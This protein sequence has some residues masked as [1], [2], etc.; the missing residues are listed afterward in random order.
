MLYSYLYFYNLQLKSSQIL[1]DRLGTRLR[2]MLIISLLLFY[3]FRIQPQQYPIIDYT[4]DRGL[5]GNQ[6]F[7]I[8]Q[9]SKGYMW[10]CTSSGLTKYNGTEYKV[11]DANDG[12]SSSIVFN[13][14]EDR[15][16]RIWIGSINSIY[17]IDS[18][19]IKSWIIGSS[20]NA[21]R[22]FV[23][24]YNRIW[25]YDFRVPSDVYYF[26]NDS[27]YNFSEDF[28]FKNQQI[29][30]ITENK[31]GSVY[32]LTSDRKVYHFL[33]SSL[34]ETP[35]SKIA[36]ENEANHLFFNSKGN[37][38]FSGNKGVIETYSSDTYESIESRTLLAEPTAYTI[39][40]KRGYYWI[41][42]S[43][44]GLYRVSDSGETIH[45]T[46]D[47]GLP[48]NLLYTL[49]QDREGNLW[50][51]ASSKGISKLSSLAITAY[52]NAEG[53]E[54]DAILFICPAE[55]NSFYCGTERGMFLFDE[56]RFERVFLYDKSGKDYSYSVFAKSLKIKDNKFI[57]A[58]LNRLLFYN[59]GNRLT[60]LELYDLYVTD[61]YQTSRGEI[62]I[63]TG[64]GLFLL[65]DDD[66]IMPINIDSPVGYIYKILEVDNRDLYVAADSGLVIIQ[67]GTIPVEQKSIHLLNKKSGLDSD[68]VDDVIVSKDNE[69]IIAGANGI[70]V[71]S[72]EN[73]SIISSFKGVMA[74]VLFSDSNGNLWAG[75]T[76]GLY[77][78]RKLN[79]KYELVTIF[80]KNNGLVSNE[81]TMPGTIW[82]DSLGSIWF[83]S[84]GGLSVFDPN[85]VAF[86]SIKP[87]FYIADIFVNDSM[88]T[89]SP[90]DNYEFAPGQNK[91]S[92]NLEALSFIDEDAVKYEYYLEPIEKPWAN[93][94][95]FN[96][97]SYGY[98]EPGLYIF[99]AR[100]IN[101]YRV[102]SVVQSA[103][104]EI[105]APVWQRSWFIALLLVAL[106]ALIYLWNYYRQANIRKRN[107]ILE[108]T[109]SKKTAELLLSKNKIEEQYNSLVEAQK[110]LVEKEKLE[111]AY[112]EIQILKNRLIQENIYLKEKHGSLNEINSI[113]GQS[114]VIK[115]LKK[116]ISEIGQT[117]STI[118]I[119]GETG[120][121]KNLVAE[122]IHALSNR[123]ERALVT[124]NCAAI[125]GSLVES[126]L[127]GHE[128]GAFTGANEKRVGKFEIADGSTVFLDEIGD[129]D[130]AIQAK[131]LNVIQSKKLTRVG[132]NKS[133]NIDV[134][135]I[136]ATNHNLQKL[137]DQ[138]IFR[139]DLYYRINV[140]EINIL[141][142]REHKDDIELLAKYFIDKY[143]RMLNKKIRRVSKSAL[144]IL[145]GYSFPGNIRELENIIHRAVILSKGD[146]I[147]DEDINPVLHPSFSPDFVIDENTKSHLITLDELER[148]YILHVLKETNWKISGQGSASEV[149]GLHFNT[150]RYRMEKLN[151]P[152]TKT[153]SS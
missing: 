116:K 135:I 6:V 104:L 15:L 25:L 129:M 4:G 143:S 73:Y 77:L 58:N 42:S 76:N 32:F 122:A 39:Q 92:F 101:P 49:L 108:E 109:V 63:G 111:K 152:F 149:L 106:M 36:F 54:E 18:K 59:S 67:N 147:T 79:D 133:I 137:V 123:K 84:V 142:L 115:N 132:G 114:T 16:G 107:L 83:G 50:I 102:S 71:L 72:K 138:G 78:F 146:V 70:E 11:Y 88:V 7:S 96:S 130:L 127:F 24:S 51:G 75:T 93:S 45:I 124:V 62:I 61:L 5:L 46:T 28:R 41:A 22:I 134:R 120:V 81:F 121:G 110:K 29:L 3:A 14:Q 150:L 48:T 80:S 145:S 94:S 117:N 112:S 144:Q 126:E 100:A 52:G 118:L 26:E 99:Y 12:F 131:L 89:T 55:N 128:K 13:V 57:F 87:L 125:P 139:R 153:K 10:F 141:P 56:G 35:F 105:L 85:E 53:L 103:S 148:S 140:V 27:I 69:I 19:E 136:T 119:T 47:N 82:E 33:S 90:N 20:I 23:D 21:Y 86:R 68:A 31:E 8:Y 64:I 44:N 65:N 151:I 38:V 60:K 43:Q 34:T 30:S 91:I 97:I 9:D 113:I 98:L 74:R 40:N 1:Q 66:T 2:N 37:L 17:R 95:K